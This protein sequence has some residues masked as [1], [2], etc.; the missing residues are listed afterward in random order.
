ML[1]SL[2]A[3]GIV[4]KAAECLLNW[5]IEFVETKHLDSHFRWPCARL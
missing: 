5:P 3:T 2:A 4:V 1:S